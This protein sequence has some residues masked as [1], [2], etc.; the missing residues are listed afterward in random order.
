MTRALD[1]G[2]DLEGAVVRWA[3][4]GGHLV[5]HDLA[6]LRE[7]LLQRRLVVDGM[8]QRVSSSGAKASTTAAAVRS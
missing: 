6:A 7:A 2:R 3:V 5:G 8:L 1:A 4:L